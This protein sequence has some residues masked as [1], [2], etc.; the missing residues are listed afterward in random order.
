MLSPPCLAVPI[1]H[2]FRCELL[3]QFPALSPSMRVRLDD[4][5]STESP[6]GSNGG[7]KPI[8]AFTNLLLVCLQQRMNCHLGRKTPPYSPHRLQRFNALTMPM[9]LQCSY[10]MTSHFTTSAIAM[11]FTPPSPP[12]FA[13]FPS[14]S[15]RR[16]IIAAI[17]PTPYSIC[18]LHS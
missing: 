2:I 5:V 11:K 7:Q 9:L 6:P 3:S 4:N 8:C 15:F 17:P 13:H 12:F 16:V 14:P 18:F 1:H 10:Y